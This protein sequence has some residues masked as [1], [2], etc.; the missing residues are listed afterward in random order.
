MSAAEIVEE[1]ERSVALIKGRG[2]LGTGFVVA[3]R[4]LATNAHVLDEEFIQDIEVRFPSAEGA[5][6][7][8]LPAA[9]FYENRNRDLA[10]LSVQTDL[11]PLRISRLPLYRKGDDI[12]V[13]GN[14]GIG[15]QLVLENAIS[16]GV[17]STRTKIDGHN[18]Y[19]LGISINPGN[20]GGPV[21]DSDGSVIGI[22]TLKTS[23]Q[24]A[25]AFCIP[26]TDLLAELNTVSD[27]SEQQKLAYQSRHR[28]VCAYKL[29][30]AGG[31]VYCIGMDL[32]RAAAM[33]DPRAA[34]VN[35][36]LKL[37]E[38]M[39]A[40]F[41]ES[42][43]PSLEAA[44]SGIQSDPTLEATTRQRINDLWTNWSR[45]RAAYA[46]AQPGP[47]LEQIRF[48]KGTHR[49]LI[50]ELQP[51]IGIAVPDAL[52]VAFQENMLPDPSTALAG[53]SPHLAPPRT[54]TPDGPVIG[55][56]PPAKGPS[57]LNRG[58]TTRR[59]RRP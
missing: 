43:F 52:I 24:E 42:V 32:H 45:M 30:V 46:Q 39:V 9:L 58:K 15:G 54:G 31:A 29:L 40:H 47:T 44:V 5:R 13:I 27:Q 23:R 51:S 12:T 18:F 37:F 33:G 19:Q 17:L 21:F 55:A 56:Q 4:L 57:A 10:L 34:A 16:R 11:P 6:Q 2:S 59:G 14:P 7:G 49:Q 36:N 1:S 38:A 48:L 41:E 26:A 25:L 35:Q 22:V 28:V 3:P 20:S 53:A 50:D 8:P